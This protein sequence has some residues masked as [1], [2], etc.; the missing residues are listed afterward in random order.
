MKL[1]DE[2]EYFEYISPPTIGCVIPDSSQPEDNL[3]K[4][5]SLSEAAK[6]AYRVK[7]KKHFGFL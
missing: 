1:E 2:D 7:P 3:D 6:H 5:K 4:L